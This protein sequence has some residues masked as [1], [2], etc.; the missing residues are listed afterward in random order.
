MRP[1]W[2]GRWVTLVL[3][4][5]GSTSCGGSERK[6]RGPAAADLPQTLTMKQQHAVIG[7]A[8]GRLRE[9]LEIPSLR[10]TRFPITEHEYEKCTAAGACAAKG[11][12]C[13]IGPPPTKAA[14]KSEEASDAPAR[15]V[16][17][18]QARAYC[19]WIGA[20]L[21]TAAEWLV[22]AR[23]TQPRL[24]AWGSKPAT[25]AQHPAG[26]LTLEQAAERGLPD[27]VL[28][29]IIAGDSPEACVSDPEL[30]LR[31]GQHPAGASPEGLHDVLLTAAE[32]VGPSESTIFAACREPRSACLVHSHRSA[33]S[34]DAFVPWLPPKPEGRKDSS[35]RA[36]ADADWAPSNPEY[37]FRCV[38]EEVRP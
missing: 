29:A 18:A 15:C 13:R 36:D 21:P 26:R 37:S 33:G 17:H 34:I 22:A 10:I 2:A 24:F 30:R 7:L 16:G 9:E 12:D 11:Q 27:G 6:D 1:N 31:V 3:V 8:G 35:D 38:T 19:S 25:C 5:A 20:R 32:L 23:G 28:Y 4:S 14:V